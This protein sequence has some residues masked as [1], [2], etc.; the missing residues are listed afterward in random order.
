MGINRKNEIDFRYGPL[1]G[2]KSD[3]SR[4]IILSEE[5]LGD[6]LQIDDKGK[7]TLNA[8]KVIDKLS[9]VNRPDS[10]G[11][12]NMFYEYIATDFSETNPNKFLYTEPKEFGVGLKL[13]TNSL[14]ESF[15]DDGNYTIWADATKTTKIDFTVVNG[16]VNS[17]SQ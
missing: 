13:F 5:M 3:G 9:L 2:I 11:L 16:L 6:D 12:A 7:L 15:A 8:E 4:V 10:G 1:V 14:L 17:I